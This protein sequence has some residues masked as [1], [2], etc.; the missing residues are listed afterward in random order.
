MLISI[1]LA[2]SLLASDLALVSVTQWPQH[3]ADT[4]GLSPLHLP[5]RGVLAYAR[6]WE[7]DNGVKLEA[8]GTLTDLVTALERATAGHGRHGSSASAMAMPPEER[9][10]W[11]HVRRLY[12]RYG[13][14]LVPVRAEA[15][16]FVARLRAA[17]HA[18]LLDDL[19]AEMTYLRVRD[20]RPWRVLDMSPHCGY[21]SFWLLAALRDN[22]NVVSSGGGGGGSGGGTVDAFD[23]LGCAAS[24]LPPALTGGGRW[25]LH[26]GD[27]LR[28]APRRLA[29]LE[30][31]LE[32]QLGAA[33][34]A[35]HGGGGGG[36]AG[37]DADLSDDDDDQGYGWDYL[38][39]DSDHSPA[40]AMAYLDALHERHYRGRPES[41]GSVHDVYLS[42]GGI[43]E[44]G[45]M[46]LSWLA[47]KPSWRRF[48][49][50]S[51]FKAPRM[52][53]SVMRLR[54]RLG[55]APR[56]SRDGIIPCG[57]T[58]CANSMAF[59]DLANGG[60]TPPL[61]AG[62]TLPRRFHGVLESTRDNVGSNWR[63]AGQGAFSKCRG[64][65]GSGC[66]PTEGEL[67]AE[68]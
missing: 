31:Q 15:R 14:D 2:G 62:A 63:D 57:Q 30:A 67:A 58:F 65:A 13:A 36:G 24:M 56:G 44:E 5:D 49:T 4:A 10:A 54:A 28:L 60:A 35:Q 33:A 48:F 46:L 52:Y 19:E 45:V 39:V 64:G 55:I 29:Q 61:G 20:L 11:E 9:A 1:A 43:T 66:V 8:G 16:A 12:E 40:F 53:V 25:T 23:V 38:F 50:L 6:Q 26:R 59:L 37:V 51:P 22:G 68:Q 7:A 17:G 21:S 3:N 32:A 41:S 27:A 42:S 18:A 34:A 47:E